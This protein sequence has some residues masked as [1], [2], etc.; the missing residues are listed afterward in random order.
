M[1]EV[2]ATSGERA[3]RGCA[4]TVVVAWYPRY[5]ELTKLSQSLA[6]ASGDRDRQCS[7]RFD[8]VQDQGGAHLNSE[9][10]IA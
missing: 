10:S 3:F 9:P 8:D 6:K 4:N 5:H 1:L 7:A 2:S